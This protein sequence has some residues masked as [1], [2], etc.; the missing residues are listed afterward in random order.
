MVS[1]KQTDLPGVRKNSSAGRQNCQRTHLLEGG[2][3]KEVVRDKK[4]DLPG[5]TENS[6]AGVEREL[7]C[8]EVELPGVKRKLP[9]EGSELSGREA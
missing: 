1:D 8:W 3:K 4:A 9:F 6:S 2:L 7:A 5:V